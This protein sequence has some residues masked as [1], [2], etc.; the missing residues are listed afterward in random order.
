MFP[1]N[2]T[3]KS[4]RPSNLVQ[5]HE[6]TSPKVTCIGQVRGKS[7]KH[8]KNNLNI[9][10]HTTTNNQSWPFTISHTFNCF[11]CKSSCFSNNTKNSNST[12]SSSN[13]KNSNDSGVL[14]G[15]VFR[16]MV[17]VHEE[18]DV[19][20]IVGDDNER[21]SSV[22]M[23]RN[24]SRRK[25]IFDDMEFDDLFNNVN[26][27][28]GC[29]NNDYDNDNDNDNDNSGDRCGRVS[30]CVPPKNA[31]LLMR[32]RS[33]PM[34]M[35][36][37]S[38]NKSFVADEEVVIKEGDYVNFD[39]KLEISEVIKEVNDEVEVEGLE[40]FGE[41]VVV[42]L[43]EEKV[44]EKFEVKIDENDENC[45]K[46]EE[47]NDDGKKLEENL[48]DMMVN[49][50]NG[51]DLTSNDSSIICCKSLEK[52]KQ[53]KSNEGSEEKNVV[54]VRKSKEKEKND[55]MLPN[56]LLL[57]MC[58]PKLSMEVSKE[59]WMCGTDFGRWLPER[60]HIQKSKK[61]EG[62]EGDEGGNSC[63]KTKAAAV[64]ALPPS[65]RGGRSGIQPGR[66]SISFPTVGESMA[67]LI[68]EKL[69]NAG[70]GY[71]PFVLT[72]CKSAPLRSE[73]RF[74]SPELG[75]L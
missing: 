68:G 47:N 11:P 2:T 38:Q 41:K 22:V 15:V 35:A 63:K 40:V 66:S 64:A 26:D 59:T 21:G 56:C 58:E 17:S 50:E 6:P 25:S 42:K 33:N 32:C 51:D 12:K 52:S 10:S 44:C 24:C 60:H 43:E 45:V 30:I 54:E 70:V 8:P 19:E 67:S 53:F 5:N 39:E 69:G 4:K 9:L 34:K 46:N 61:I 73:A 1:K 16:W 7:K 48:I 31:L 13:T 55:P 72:R 75:C 65:G 74:V 29:N 49:Q 23:E 14:C 71:D 62:V 3:K 18:N 57:M 28:V 27:N 37:L 20:L 36:S